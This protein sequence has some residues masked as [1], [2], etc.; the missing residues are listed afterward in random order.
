M[1]LFL[2]RG[3]RERCFYSLCQIAG[4]SFAPIVKKEVAGILFGHVVMYGDDVDAALA[5]GFEDILKFGFFDDEIAI[6]NGSVAP[7]Y[8]ST[9]GVHAHF[10]PRLTAARHLCETSENRF[11]HAVIRV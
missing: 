1:A 3:F 2:F 7:A 11:V 6:D 10:F 8:E 5:K 9:P 4:F